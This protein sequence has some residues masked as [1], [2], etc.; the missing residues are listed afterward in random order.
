M[1]YGMGILRFEREQIKEFI[2]EA[3]GTLAVLV[4]EL[5]TVKGGGGVV[6]MRRCLGFW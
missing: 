4:G 6:L 3:A 1:L 2:A 5:A